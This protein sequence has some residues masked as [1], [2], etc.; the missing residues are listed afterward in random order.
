MPRK[1]RRIYDNDATVIEISDGAP[2]TETTSITET[3]STFKTNMLSGS[4]KSIPVVLVLENMAG[5]MMP[6]FRFVN[7]AEKGTCLI[8]GKE[9]SMSARRLCGDCMRECGERL[10]NLARQAI[11]EGEKEVT[12]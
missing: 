1:S 2:M 10:Y 4:G 8:C 9:T 3:A 12:I 5:Y 7:T 11:D 6:N